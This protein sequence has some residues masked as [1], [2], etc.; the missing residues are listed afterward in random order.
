MGEQAL[1]NSLKY[2]LSIIG[3][4]TDFNLVLK[5]YSKLYDGRYDPKTK[6]LTLYLYEDKRL[7]KLRSYEG[8]LRT[9][10]HE[11]T[12]HYQWYYEVGFRRVKGVMHDSQFLQI[13][14]LWILKAF[15]YRL[16]TKE[17]V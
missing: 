12:H 16:L 2:D 1:Y 17:V 10:I 9:A 6:K 4:P 7:S 8:I 15:D 13:E 5:K 3:V 14:R 11:A